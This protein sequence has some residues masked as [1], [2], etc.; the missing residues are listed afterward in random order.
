VAG[1]GDRRNAEL[2]GDGDGRVV[3]RDRGARS[4]G[5]G[6]GLEYAALSVLCHR[7]LSQGIENEV[8][9]K[10]ARAMLGPPED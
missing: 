1:I 4:D 5:A 3:I 8:A 9:A 2:A 6:D 7:Q 10:S